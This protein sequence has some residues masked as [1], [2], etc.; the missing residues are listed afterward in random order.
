[1]K[2]RYSTKITRV[3]V[4]A[5]IA[6]FVMTATSV[7]I[8]QCPMCRSA[9]EAN[10]KLGGTAAKGLNTGILY[11]FAMPYIVVGIIAILWWRGSKRKKAKDDAYKSLKT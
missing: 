11:L 4:S 3:L 7:I 8:A 1:M 6:F 2:K 10:V 9:A 5:L